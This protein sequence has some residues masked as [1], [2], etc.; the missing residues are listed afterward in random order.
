MISNIFHINLNA[1]GGSE[2][3]SIT[4]MYSLLSIDNMNV[5]LSTFD[6]P[7]F[8]ILHD[9]YGGC[10]RAVLEKIA[11]INLISSVNTDSIDN[12]KYDLIV[13]THGD[14]LPMVTRKMSEHNSIT[15]CHFPLGCYLMEGN[16]PEY[17]A[18]LRYDNM[19]SCNGLDSINFLKKMKRSYS[20]MMTNSKILTNSEFSRKVIW[21][22]FNVDSTILYPPV[23]VDIFRNNVLYSSESIEKD[24]KLLVISR[25]HP[26]KKI[27]NA[28]RFAKLLKE[29]NIADGMKIVGNLSLDGLAY[30][31]YLKRIVK[32]YDLEDF[33]EFKV[34]VKLRDL[35]DLMLKSKVYFHPLPGEPFGISTVEAMS[36]GLIPVVPDLGGHT[37]FVPRRYQ[38]HTFKSA[39]KVVESALAAPDSEKYL[40]SNCV[41]KFSIRHYVLRFR[42]IVTEMLAITANDN[43]EATNEPTPIIVPDKP[44]RPAIAGRY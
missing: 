2:R 25:F 24:K 31:S 21:K 14:M 38:F 10:T 1:R 32:N 39:I 35:I 8:S 15:Y 3:L 44:K 26:S 5:E 40:I 9:A 28:V 20:A 17:M 22:T 27:E 29:C 11:S 34:N 6:I 37:E 41:S 7:D 23:D 13:N 33:V 4:T 12:K 19:G 36:A 16:D 43:I 42:E 30:Y 18:L